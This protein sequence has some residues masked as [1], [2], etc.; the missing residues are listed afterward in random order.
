MDD[1]ESMKTPS[2]VDFFIKRGDRLPTLARTLQ[3][4]DG[5]AIDLTGCTVTWVMR[6]KVGGE[7]KVSA[8]ATIVSALEG[9]VEYAWASPD[10]S[11]VGE[12]VGEWRV[13][14]PDGKTLTVPTLNFVTVHVKESLL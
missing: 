6:T 4:Q 5:S 10:T 1:G 2:A 11:A 7:I 3:Y 8:P 13:L 14:Y 9:R 12:F